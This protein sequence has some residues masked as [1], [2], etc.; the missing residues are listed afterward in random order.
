MMRRFRAQLVV[1]NCGD[2]HT[3]GGALHRGTGYIEILDQL[4]RHLLPPPEPR[5]SL[6][7][8]E[9]VFPRRDEGGEGCCERGKS[10]GAVID[11][12]QEHVTG[13]SRELAAAGMS[14]GGIHRVLNEMMEAGELV[15]T[16]PLRS[17]KQRYRFA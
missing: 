13:S 7:A 3:H 4:Q 2:K 10:R 14:V 16:E 5:D 6:T 15:C 11:Y 9:L 8:F 17:P 1:L 12:V